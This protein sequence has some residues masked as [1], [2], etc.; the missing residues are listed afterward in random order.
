MKFKQG[1]NRQQTH[2]FPVSL[3]AS[4]D[5]DNEARIIDLFV[6]SLHIFESIFRLSEEYSFLLPT[7]LLL[8]PNI[9]KSTIFASK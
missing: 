1:H 3:D 6:E 5:P 4:I 8:F 2:L 9:H 7:P